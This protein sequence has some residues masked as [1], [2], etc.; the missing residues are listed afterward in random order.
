VQEE[1]VLES[2]LVVRI[3]G[4]VDGVASGEIRDDLVELVRVGVLH[5]HGLK[6]VFADVI[7]VALPCHLLDDGTEHDV[8]GIAVLGSGPGFKIQ[9]DL[10]DGFHEIVH[11]FDL[12]PFGK[13]LSVPVVSHAALHGQQMLDG[14]FLGHVLGEAFHVLTYGVF[15]PDAA[16][17]EELGDGHLDEGLVDGTDVELRVYA[18]GDVEFLAGHAAGF[19][20]QGLAV[21]GD[22]DRAGEGVVFLHPLE[23]A[24]DPLEN[25]T[26]WH[27]FEGL[28]FLGG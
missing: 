24:L 16:F 26:L 6:D 19:F 27:A 25:F 4:A 9:R 5:A 2:V 7:V 28:R 17:F 8:A 23:L 12:G 11:G 10:L 21:L 13:P 22:E 18:V 14:D 15:Q 20:K 3:R 1:V